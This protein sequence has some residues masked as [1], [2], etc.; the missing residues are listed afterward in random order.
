MIYAP[1]SN[2]GTYLFDKEG[3]YVTIPKN[4]VVF[5]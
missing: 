2:I 4:H 5:T 1:M 3:D